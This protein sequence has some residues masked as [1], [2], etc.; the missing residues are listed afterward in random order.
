MQAVEGKELVME[1]STV[2]E[3]EANGLAEGAVKGS[4]ESFDLFGGQSKSC[5]EWCLDS[6]SLVVPLLVCHAG[7]MI[8]RS[9]RGL[10]GRKSF[11]LRKSEPSRKEVATHR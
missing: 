7:S 6:S 10:D 11:E 8:S 3:S 4:K 2:K 5:M 9:R 1:D